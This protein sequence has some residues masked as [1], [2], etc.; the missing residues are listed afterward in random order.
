MFSCY[1]I[2]NLCPSINEAVG[3]HLGSS[4]VTGFGLNL[5]LLVHFFYLLINLAL[6]A[7]VL[8][9]SQYLNFTIIVMLVFLNF[10]GPR[11]RIC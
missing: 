9:I 4:A 1:L 5:W 10:T 7:E 11:K 2:W 8:F 3:C 6:N